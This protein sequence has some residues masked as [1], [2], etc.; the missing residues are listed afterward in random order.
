MVSKME[1]DIGL[2]FALVEPEMD[3]STLP[4]QKKMKAGG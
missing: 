1:V 3:F 2:T 4:P